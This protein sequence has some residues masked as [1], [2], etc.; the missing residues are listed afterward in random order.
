MGTTGSPE[1]RA[2]PL[3]CVLGIH[4][5]AWVG[6]PGSR[7][8]YRACRRCRK[9][10]YT[11]GPDAAHDFYRSGMDEKSQDDRAPGGH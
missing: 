7:E 3:L 4:R 2:R 11:W 6:G 5:W 1:Q 8:A 10:R 9:R